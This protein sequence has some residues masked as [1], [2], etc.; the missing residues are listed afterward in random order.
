MGGGPDHK[1]QYY[2]QSLGWEGVQ[3]INYSTITNPWDGR[4]VQTINY[5]TITNPWDGRGGP[6]HKLQYYYQS[7]GWEGGQTI[8][9][10]TVEPHLSEP[11]LSGCSDYPTFYIKRLNGIFGM[12]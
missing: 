8:N 12:H 6:D 5:S 10:S 3:T 4:E 2:Y 1:L 11:H 7:L 9:Y